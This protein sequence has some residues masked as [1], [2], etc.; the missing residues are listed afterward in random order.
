M[1]AIVIPYF[2][3]L[4][5][6]ETLR[7]LANQTDK[8]FK[9][10]I[11]DDASPE[12]PSVL[13]EKYKGQ[14]A[15]VYHRFETN[16]GGISLVQQWDRC[17]ALSSDEEWLMVL[18]DDDYL[19]NNFVASWYKHYNHFVDKANVIRF[20]S[21]LINEKGEKSTVYIHPIWECANSSF[22]R[23]FEYL[24]RSSLSEYVFS[25]DSYLKY[26]FHGYPLAW[27][28]DDRAWFDFSDKK[29]L[30]TI[31]EAVVFVR[32]SSCSISGKKDN[33]DLKNKANYE[34]F[35]YIVKTKLAAFDQHQRHRILD[36]Y[37]NA[38]KEVRKLKVNEWGLIIYSYLKF[39]DWVSL[40]RV[41]KRLVKQ[42]LK[43][44]S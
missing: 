5:L 21:I 26:G 25:R 17:I 34:F 20:A 44:E 8:R 33:M 7:S 1:I 18:G 12:N 15:F 43:Y 22:Y 32:L 37:E 42:I 13:L 41:L 9:L 3:I 38:I 31:N 40:K 36:R 30:Y 28:S 4:F 16:L 35:N 14:F 10:Y 24:T 27:N 11:G 2:K 23:K 39:Y 6:E 29:P 19:D